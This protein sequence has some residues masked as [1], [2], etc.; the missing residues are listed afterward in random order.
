MRHKV[1]HVEAG[2]A[3]FN[4]NL[5][6]ELLEAVLEPVVLWV[7][8]SSVDSANL[9]SEVSDP[10]LGGLEDECLLFLYKIILIGLGFNSC[11]NVVNHVLE[12]FTLL[13]RFG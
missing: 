6:S 13:S 3:H 4:L 12:A 11:L 1:N 7:L 10:L 9:R 2:I 5:L 8:L